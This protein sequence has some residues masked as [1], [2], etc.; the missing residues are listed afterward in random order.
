[1]NKHIVL[2]RHG[3]TNGNIEGRYIGLKTD[4]DLCEEGYKELIQAKD[5]YQTEILDS[6]LVYSSPM[7]RAIQ[8][9]KALFNVDDVTCIDDLAEIDFG[10]FEN[11]NYHE[12]NGNLDYQRWIDSGGKLDYPGGEALSS[13]I[14]RSVAGFINVILDMEKRH[15]DT[16]VVICH[17]GNIMAIMS[18][19]TG[20]DYFDFQVDNASGY[21]LNVGCI[22]G[23]NKELGIRINDV[24]LV[25][26][27]RI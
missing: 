12:L 6:H 19:L 5:K 20:R 10:D 7:K 9:A 14:D 22:Q 17:G 11:K 1:M 4:E 21:E 8:T 16:A 15:I 23:A 3:K 2:I 18:S 25:S 26:Y 27:N 24:D 13:F